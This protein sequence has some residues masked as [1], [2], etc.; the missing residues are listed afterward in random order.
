MTLIAK[1]STQKMQTLSE[2]MTNAREAGYKEDFQVGI[3]GLTTSKGSFYPPHK[4]TINNFYRFEG[5]SDPADNAILYLIETSDHTKGILIDAYD[6]YAD[7]RVSNF[8][9][10][11]DGIHKKHANKGFHLVA[12]LKNIFRKN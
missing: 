11:V 1:D 8:I 5:Y 4:V 10:Q 6:T 12:S 7:A 3:S 9:R 2:C